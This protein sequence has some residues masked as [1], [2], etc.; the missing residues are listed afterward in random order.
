MLAPIEELFGL[1]RQHLTNRRAGRFLVEDDHVS[2]TREPLLRARALELLDRS[3]T[4]SG[5]LHCMS[6]DPW[7][8][9]W[10]PNREAFLPF[11]ERP[12]TLI[13]WRDPVGE[14]QAAAS[15][16]EQARWLAQQSGKQ[17]VIL[18]ASP[19]VKERAERLGYGSLQVGAEQFF[20]LH[21]FTTKGKRG[22]KVRLACNHARRLGAEAREFFP[23]RVES[24][25]RAM[26]EVEERW[27]GAREARRNDSFLRTAPLEN[28]A[29]RRYFAVEMPS[30]DG[31]KLMQSF[32]VCSPVSARGWY[33]QDL[34]RLPDAPRGAT[35]LVSMTAMQTFQREGFD[36]VSMGIVPM[37]ETEPTRSEPRG[38]SS[39][40]A[41]WCIE[42][43]NHLYRFAGL[44]QFRA[45]FAATTCEAV[46]VA[47]W[48]RLVTPWLAYDVA[49][50]LASR[51]PDDARPEPVLD[52]VA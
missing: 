42:R 51:R 49:M 35:E 45:K 10:S 47:H 44:R 43:F 28:A 52:W 30:Q 14:P 24:D 5:Q 40:A 13:A 39:M 2:C 22:E 15:L 18:G 31:R 12:F 26:L 36:F 7:R 9:L 20:D 6:S 25:R 38:L 16:L 29:Y 3:S 32:L 11:L 19:A 50:T 17:L 4:L 41:R 1:A 34:V 23:T 48:P 21:Q 27:K 46:Y 8:L 33:L 37:L